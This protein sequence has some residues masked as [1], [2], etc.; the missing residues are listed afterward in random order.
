MRVLEARPRVGGRLMTAT[1]GP[2]GR[3]DLG[4]TWH[5]G[6]DPRVRAL[7]A[8]LGLATFSQPVHGDALIEEQEGA[9]RRVHLPGDD[10]RRF[11]GGTQQLCERLAERLSP[12]TIS[13]GA[14]AEAVTAGAVGVE[15]SLAGPDG[16]STAVAGAV[17]VALP[18]RLVLQALSFSPALPADLVRAMEGTPTWMGEALKCVA[19]YDEPFWRESGLSGTALSAVGPL[20]EVHDA[21]ELEGPAALWGFV[22]LDPDWRAMGP[23]DRVPAVLAQLERLFGPQ[24]GDPVQYLERDWSADPNTSEDEHRHGP[25]LAFGHPAF[26]ISSWDGRL[27]WAGTETAAEGGGHME[28]AVVA[29][30]RAAR[31]IAGRS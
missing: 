9:P 1:S 19:V 27:V 18:P 6:N 22:A 24:A 11:A 20:S 16:P 8:D 10:A 25:V 7:A 23:Q 28:G 29:G 14:R 30:R 13:F 26:S 17:I 3:F 12:G 5:W 15:V 4:A 31:L 2:G 21:T